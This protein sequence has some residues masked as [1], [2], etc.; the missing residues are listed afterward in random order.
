MPRPNR[1]PYL[2]FLKKRKKYYI[3]WS[4]RGQTRERS[5]GTADQFEAQE[6]LGKFIKSIRQHFGP[7]P[8][9]KYMIVDAIENYVDEHA[10]NTT[11]P[12]RI[13]Y[14]V[15]AL[16]KYWGNNKV[17]DITRQTC[18]A[19]QTFRQKSDSTVRRE[20]GVLRAAINHDHK[21]GRVTRSPFVW[22]PPKPAGKDRWLTKKEAAAL[23]WAA[24][25]EPKVRLYL[26]LFIMLG[27][28]TGARKEAILSLRWPQVNLEA[29]RI[30]LNPPGRMQTSKRRPVL[31][32][33]GRLMVALK[34]AR[35]RGHDLGY[36]VHKDGER[37]GDIKKSFA[38]AARN[39]G[40]EN[41]TPH[42]L[43]HTSGTWMAQAG[44]PLFQIAGWLGHSNER[45][46]ALYS[47]HHADYLSD[48]MRAFK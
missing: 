36:V 41:V 30:D 35:S 28:Y 42:T 38:T 40:L 47:H 17:S 33:P 45:T 31:P 13:G 23:L 11:C 20:L 37:L 7:L 15:D 16:L 6:E 3:R 27:L 18:E 32:I 34:H 29:R 19:Y 46:T 26:P 12:E 5:T 43:R 24:K 4:E 25:S 48:A 10:V 44:V 39:A 1:G 22:L 9:E 2:V 8:P 21:M 14:A